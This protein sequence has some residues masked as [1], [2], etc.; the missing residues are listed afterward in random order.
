MANIIEGH[1]MELK[2]NG[3]TIAIPDDYR[4]EPLIWILHDTLMLNGTRYGCGAGWCGCCTVLADNV[5]IRSC[6][7]SAAKV[8][9]QEI[10]T[11]EGLTEENTLH[12]AVK[13]AFKEKPLQCCYCMTGHMMTAIALLAENQNPSQDEIDEA[14]D[15]NLC[16]CGGYKLIRKNVNAASEKLR[17]QT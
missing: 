15:K 6:Q 13:N 11:L 8:V 3:K 10:I 4:D 16:R 12:K 14:M 9:G 2:L 7:I 5:P 1:V 17:G